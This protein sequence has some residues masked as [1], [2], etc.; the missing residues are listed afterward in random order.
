VTFDFS[1]ARLVQVD[2][3]SGSIANSYPVD[4]AL[5]GDAGLV[6]A[7]LI[8]ALGPG[9]AVSAEPSW[10]TELD[11]EKAA[12]SVVVRES[13]KPG[14]RGLIGVG[15]VVAALQR[16]YADT[17]LNFV[18]DVGKHHKWVTQQF[19]SREDDY[20]INSVAAGVMGLGPA[21][22][23]GAALARPSV[24]TIAWTGDGGMAMALYTWPTV[25]EHR[26][27]IKYVVIDD[28]AYG[29]VANI[30]L[31]QFGRTVFS[32]FNAGGKNSAYRLDLAA[33]AAAIGIPSRK[34][35]EPGEIADAVAW[36]RSI[37]GPTVIDVH[38]DRKSVAPSGGGKYLH[39]LWDHRPTPW[40]RGPAA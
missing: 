37:D 1:K 39:A 16:Q 18:C 5:V 26:L 34:V 33:V 20:V 12:W 38:A 15:A 28:G 10:R 24:P 21:G 17:P 30:E 40:T 4:E 32:E 6:L 31:A 23:V 11:R 14:S 35:E 19:E 3:D 13:Q 27:P 25:A 22:A 29:A 7:D 36:A 8:A 9:A 2:I